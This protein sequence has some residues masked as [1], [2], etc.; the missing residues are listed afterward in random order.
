M[1]TT[2][3]K[4]TRRKKLDPTPI[5]QLI[6]EGPLKTLLEKANDIHTLN[7]ILVKHLPEALKSFYQVANLRDHTL[8]IY[9][10]NATHATLLRYHLPQLL[11]TFQKDFTKKKITDIKTCIKPN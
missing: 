5:N 1:Q 11:R 10:G 2:Y 6:N 8:V 3:N 7:Q 9:T 4:K